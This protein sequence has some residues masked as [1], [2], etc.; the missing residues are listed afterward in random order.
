[1]R[2]WLADPTVHNWLTAI[3]GGAIVLQFTPGL[4]LWL[5]FVLGAIALICGVICFPRIRTKIQNVL[6]LFIGFLK[7]F[8]VFVIF[9]VGIIATVV[10]VLP[11]PKL[12][13][14]VLKARHAV[15][16]IQ[17]SMSEGSV[18]SWWA[19]SDRSYKPEKTFFVKEEYQLVVVENLDLESQV[20]RTYIMDGR[21][22]ASD[23]RQREPYPFA[24]KYYRSDGCIFATEFFDKTGL[25]HHL[26]YDKNCTGTVETFDLSSPVLLPPVPLLTYR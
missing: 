25:Y 24:R 6:S 3:G 15:V 5:R 12:P 22:I 16:E 4:P 23:V 10:I 18:R 11:K 7:N 26:D 20:V 19:A 9:L 8:R 17:T 14:D 13:Q 2:N 21:K 1:V